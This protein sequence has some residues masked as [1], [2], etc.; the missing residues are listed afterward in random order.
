MGTGSQ[1]H[2]LAPAD[3]ELVDIVGKKLLKQDGCYRFLSKF[4]GENYGVVRKF[5]E[6]YD[7]RRVTIGILDFIVDR[8]FIFEETGL[9]QIGKLWFKGKTVLTYF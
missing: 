8:E 2:W 9:H 6:T 5:A 4:S 7:G 1:P 3:T